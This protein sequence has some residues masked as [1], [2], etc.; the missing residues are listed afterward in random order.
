M[1]KIS[2]WLFIS[3]LCFIF[4]AGV[5]YA[6]ELS[7]PQKPVVDNIPIEQANQ[8][9][10][11]YN[12]QVDEYNNQLQQN[13]ENAIKE[14]DEHNNQVEQQ[15]AAD[16]EQ[17]DKDYAQYEKD[18]AFEERVVADSRYDSIEQYNEAVSQY[19]TKIDAYND[20][21]TDYHE[22]M[23][24]TNEI[25]AGAVQ[26]NINAPRISGIKDTYTI[27]K[28]EIQSDDTIPVYVEHIFL[29]TNI[30]YK[31]EF[32]IN[33]KDTITFVGIAPLVGT[34]VGDSCLFFYNTDSAHT[35]G[36]WS[37]AWSYLSTNANETDEWRNGDVHI[38]SFKDQDLYW[39]FECIEMFYYYTWSPLYLLRDHAEYAN[40]PVLPST[41]VK[42]ELFTYPNKPTF[43]THMDYLSEIINPDNNNTDNYGALPS[44]TRMSVAYTDTPETIVDDSNPLAAA[45]NG[46]WALVNLICMV[47]NILLLIIIPRRKNRFQTKRFYKNNI[48]L[49]I[50]ALVS[51][52]LFILTE[53]IWL[54]MVLVDSWTIW[55]IIICVLGII[56]KC[57]SR[58]RLKE[59]Q[60]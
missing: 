21:I 46:S 31:T 33:T 40:V 17:Y 24:V 28:G 18:K 23:G 55:M 10:D 60:E 15:Y 52:I 58:K 48:F 2:L 22:K 5:V 47:I 50:C 1:K 11:D 7:P 13:Y 9:I 14:V 38:V 20:S 42:G 12:N 16:Q 45:S 37:N 8:L 25:A 39:N 59:E 49:V 19:N 34:A 6:D 30:S 4:S 36:I 53:N 26:S 3:T 27:S 35:Q 32:R 41:P 29:G 56:L 43:L 44:F 54:P 51:V 57:T